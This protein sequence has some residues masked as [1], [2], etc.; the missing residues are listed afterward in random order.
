MISIALIYRKIKKSHKERR[1]EA[2]R[3]SLIDIH[4]PGDI[5]GNHCAAQRPIFSM[6]ISTLPSVTV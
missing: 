1:R 5:R 4:K 2:R 3:L 6:E